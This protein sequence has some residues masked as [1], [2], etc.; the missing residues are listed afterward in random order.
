MSTEVI[1]DIK[2]APN[3]ITFGTTVITFITD[4]FNPI[5]SKQVTTD[6]HGRTLDTYLKGYCLGAKYLVKVNGRLFEDDYSTYVV[7]PNDSIVYVPIISGGGGGGGAKQVITLVALVALTIATAGAAAPLTASL[8]AA[9]GITSTIGLSVLSATLMVAGTLLI[10]AVLAPSGST[11]GVT[12][13]ETESSTYSWTGIQTS[14]DLNTA[15]PVLYGT[16]ALG[17]TVINNRFY[18][19]GTND[20]LAIQLALC[21]GEI[22]Q[23]T[24]DD[25]KIEDADFSTFVGNPVGTDG[26]FTYTSGRFDQPIMNGFSDSIYNNGAA[27]H[28]LQYNTIYSFTTEST[29]IDFFRLHFEFPKGLYHMDSQGY[30]STRTVN[31]T[32]KYRRVGDTLWSNLH[33]TNP[34]YRTEY[35]YYTYDDFNGE[36]VFRREYWTT[37]YQGTPLATRKIL[38]GYATSNILQFSSKSSV[39]LKRYFEPTNSDGKPIVLPS[40]QYEFEIKRTTANDLDTDVYNVSESHVRF[41]EEINTADINYGGIAMIGVNIKATDQLSS[42][43]PNFVTTVTRKPLYLNGAYRDSTNP[44][45]ICYDILTN[46]HYGMGLN[47]NKINVSEFIRWA[48]FCDGIINNTYSI[49]KPSTE[50]N[51]INSYNGALVIP[52][53]ELPDGE[54]LTLKNINK[55]LSSLTAIG[56]ALVNNQYV[57]IDLDIND[58][59]KITRVYESNNPYRV[60]GYYYYINFTY[61]IKTSSLFLYTLVHKTSATETTPKLSFNGV[62]DT[63]SDIWTSVQEVARVGRG[64]VVLQGAKYSCIYDAPKTVSGLYNA[65]NSNNITINY[66]NR[67]DIASELEIQYSDKNIGYEMTSISVQDADMMSSGARSNKTSQIAKGITTEAEALVYGRYLLAT[68]KYIRRVVTLDADIESIT[69]SVGDLIAVQTDVTQY[70]KGGLVKAAA[71]QIITLDDMIYLE[72]NSQYTLKIKRA[73]DDF[74]KDYDFV[75]TVTSPEDYLSFNS[76]PETP[77]G[78]ITF[79]D[80]ALVVHEVNGSTV[81]TNTLIIPEGYEITKDDRYS[82]GLK[83]SDSIL[84]IITDISRDGELTRQI[85]AAEYNESILDFNY[86]NDV[87]QRLE[88]TV[89]PKN[90]ISNLQISDRLVKNEAN[91]TVAMMS[92]AWDSTV[93]SYYN[94][95]IMEDDFKNYLVMGIKGNRYEY[96]AVELTPEVQYRVYIEDA[97]DMGIITYKDYIITS[98]SSPPEDILEFTV[99][100]SGNSLEFYVDYPNQPLDFSHYEVFLDDTLVSKQISSHFNLLAIPNKIAYTFKLI[101]IDTIGKKGNSITRT[102]SISAPVISSITYSQEKEY[103]KFNIAASSSNFGIDYYEFTSPGLIG[104]SKDPIVSIIGDWVGT[105]TFTFKAYDVMGTVS[106]SYDVVVNITVPIPLNVI[107]SIDIKDAII[108]W[109]S[110]SVGLPIEYYEVEY[111]GNVYKTKSNQYRLPVYWGGSK[112]FKIRAVNTLGAVSNSVTTTIVISTGTMTMLKTEVIDNN[113]LLRWDSSQGSLPIENFMLYRG[114][115]EL[116]LEVIGEKKGT[117]TTIFENS[118]GTYTYWMAPIDSAGNIGNKLSATT[119]V[120][121]PPDY[122]LNVDWYSTFSGTLVHAKMEDGKMFLPINTTETVENHFITRS[123]TSAQ[124]QVTAGYPLWIEPF[125]SSGSYTETFDYGT[126]LASSMVSVNIDKTIIKGTPSVIVTISLSQ[127]DITYTDYYNQEQV[128]GTGFRYVKVKIDV[129]GTNSAVS[130]NTINVRLDSKLI[131]DAGTGAVTNASTGVLVNFTKPFIDVISIQV[132]PTGNTPL[133]AVY[134]FVDTPNPTQFTV[135]LYDTTGTRVT[136]NFSWGAR[137]Y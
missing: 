116:T 23:I 42:Q 112:D 55:N 126:L 122:V 50:V 89:R 130:I 38:E 34:I 137:G 44:A 93:S 25:I 16:H 28:Q 26:Y 13:P 84:C 27:A 75:A 88:P 100:P 105:K 40:G 64:Q 41:I 111:D 67:A 33:Q 24:E 60:D 53:T 9:M 45:W 48:A 115:D 104:T 62:F 10:N 1:L 136:G 132:T 77:V 72:V 20:W 113:V 87:L 36:S 124:D 76:F 109:D 81:S 103:I 69:Q 61:P 5:E 92:L 94:M 65:A 15:I 125:S 3:K 133:F 106:N 51:N 19:K 4:P 14:R 83:G 102:I 121:Q 12:S 80:L 79:G 123:W 90:I 59:V 99:T 91:T 2:K 85:T 71:G 108:R 11:G 17:G 58:I 96:A 52:Q 37:S 118:A 117:F 128:Y 43:R 110:P 21:H 29:N 98:F 57:D 134:D 95:Y 47:P 54:Y 119:M 6:L 135:Y 114:A 70:G 82:F 56:S 8:G 31:I 78:V 107:S 39:A 22:E 97:N 68:S 32:A 127:D 120:N 129:S 74:I 63:T 49:S 18:Y 46:K 66:M 73:S 131:N 35:K 7:K 101:P 30:K 86:D